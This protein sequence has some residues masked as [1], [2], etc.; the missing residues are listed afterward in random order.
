MTEADIQTLSGQLA[1]IKRTLE[2]FTPVNLGDRRSYYGLPHPISM[3]DEERYALARM[4][5]QA[6]NH[7]RD[8]NF[9]DGTLRYLVSL[10]TV[11]V[12]L[13]QVLIFAGVKP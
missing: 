9:F 4:I 11:L 6:R 13:L 3:D 5:A 12:V 10:A 7:E 1:D 2:R 8:K